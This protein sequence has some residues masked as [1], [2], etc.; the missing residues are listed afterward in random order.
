MA[1]TITGKHILYDVSL[2]VNGVDLSNRVERIEMRL[3]T[4]KQVGSAMGDIQ[5]YSIPGTLVVE[6]VTAEFYADF[7]TAKVYATLYAAWL[8]RTNFDIVGKASSGANSSTNPAWTI[9][10]FVQSM[11]VM[12][13]S[14][15]DR[16]M[17]PVTFATAGA[18][19]VATV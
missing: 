10:V 5:D 14:R 15:G 9:P 4:N 6:D 11:P 3:S 19:T 12:Q 13:G 8:A 18:Y 1:G 17:A 7:D 16:H 2:V